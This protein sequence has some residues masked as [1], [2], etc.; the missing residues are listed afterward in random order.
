MTRPNK[1]TKESNCLRK[2]FIHLKPVLVIRREKSRDNLW[3]A[4]RE[5]TSDPFLCHGFLIFPLTSVAKM[6]SENCAQWFIK[7]LLKTS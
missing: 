3:R 7:L 5:R 4:E 2:S 6:I 1:A